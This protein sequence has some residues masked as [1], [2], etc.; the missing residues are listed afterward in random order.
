[1]LVFSHYSNVQFN[2]FQ[3]DLARAK[4]FARIFRQ[5]RWGHSNRIENTC[6]TWKANWKYMKLTIKWFFYEKFLDFFNKEKSRMH[7]DICLSCRKISYFSCDF[8]FRIFLA[9]AKY[10]LCF[11]ISQIWSCLFVHVEIPYRKCFAVNQHCLP[12]LKT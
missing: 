2:C 6:K 12:H 11:L 5:L 10:F 3:R 8:L 9:N 7:S 1:M 4:Q